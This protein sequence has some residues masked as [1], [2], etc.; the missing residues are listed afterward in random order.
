MAFGYALLSVC[1]FRILAFSASSTAFFVLYVGAG[2]PVGACLAQRL[3][4]D[5]AAALGFSIRA[6]W[7]LLL[8]VPLAGWLATRGVGRSSRSRTSFS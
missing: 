5:R 2:M 1:L 6:L 4:V 8:L 7:G 3:R